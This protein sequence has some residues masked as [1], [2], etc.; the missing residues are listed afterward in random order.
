MGKQIYQSDF[1]NQGSQIPLN[2]TIQKLKTNLN[3]IKTAYARVYFKGTFYAKKSCQCWNADFYIIEINQNMLKLWIVV[4]GGDFMILDIEGH[5][6][7]YIFIIT[8]S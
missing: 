8:A 2:I 3:V 5:S 1:Q 4:T 7:I 6:K